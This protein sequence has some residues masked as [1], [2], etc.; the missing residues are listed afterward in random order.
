M[1]W[2]LC[3]PRIAHVET[4]WCAVL[5][6]AVLWYAVQSCAGLGYQPSA[7]WWACYWAASTA[8]LHMY[9]PSELATAIS[10]AGKLQQ[11]CQ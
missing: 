7:A 9:S 6:C 10:A 5:W 1:L 4:L 3:R 2:N 11:V 8:L